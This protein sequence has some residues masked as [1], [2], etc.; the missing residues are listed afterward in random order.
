[1]KLSRLFIPTAI[2]GA[3]LLSGCSTG[4][5]TVISKDASG[6]A[7][8]PAGAAS[9]SV[10]VTGDVGGEIKLTSKTPIEAGDKIERTVLK[11]GEAKPFAEGQ[12]ATG[13][14]TIFNGKTGEVINVAPDMKF[15]NEADQFA[16]AKWAYEAVRC[17]S[18]GQRTVI[19]SSVADALGDVDPAERGFTG[20]AKTDAFVFVF[21]FTEAAEVC[22]DPK[23]RDEKYPEVD[24]GDGKTEPTI[25]IP[26]CMEAPAE[27]ELKVLEEGDG[28]VVADN[29]KIMTNYVGVD[30]NGAERFDGNWSE[31]GIEFSTAE[32]AL[33]EGFR[34]AMIG[35]KVGSTILVTMPS[36]MGYNDGMTRTFVLQLVSKVE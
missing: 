34:Q 22:D 17:G 9:K 23:P 3:L 31:T 21:D 12:V 35:Q 27:L 19:V 11:N 8:A 32:G 24:M 36:E 2:V 13:N 25:T 26:S 30:W 14:Y 20:L 28:P 5:D 16:D 33:V 4:S 10:K 18:V 1:M 15:P 29:E 7:C 6:E